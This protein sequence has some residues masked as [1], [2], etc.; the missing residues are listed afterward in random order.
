[1]HHLALLGGVP[2]AAAGLA[3]VAVYVALPITCIGSA[4]YHAAAGRISA[5]LRIHARQLQILNFDAVLLPLIRPHSPIL[6][7]WI[8]FFLN[9]TVGLLD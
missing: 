1:M 2:G 5:G 8:I 4:S 3:Y 6:Q 9:Q 7:T